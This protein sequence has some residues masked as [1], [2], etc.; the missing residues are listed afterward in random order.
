MEIP[1]TAKRIK[2]SKDYIDIDGS[3]YSINNNRTYKKTQILKN[4]YKYC[5]IEYNDGRKCFKSVQN[6]VANTF[7]KNDNSY[8]IIRHRNNIK[9]DNRVDNLYWYSGDKKIFD[10]SNK[11]IMMFSRDNKFINS[12]DSINDAV[13]ETNI[14][15]KTISRQVKYKRP[16]NTPYYFR[17]EDDLDVI[18]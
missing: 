16:V 8:K 14:S 1:K 7:L 6:L 9:T 2:Y 15:E 11:R 18:A 10:N 17:Y 4:G 12:F 3:I 5:N 13:I